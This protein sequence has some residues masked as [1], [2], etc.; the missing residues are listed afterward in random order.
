MKVFID[1]DDVIFNT[2]EFSAGLRKL[3]ESC[4][5]S[6]E[7]FQKNYYD[8]SDNNEIKLFDPEGVFA[9]LEKNEK[10]ETAILREK[11]AQHM[12]DL[13]EFVFADVADFLAETEKKNA[14]LI[15]FGLPVFQNEK[16]VAS[17]IH[18]LVSGCIVTKGSKAEAVRQVMEKMNI[19]FDEKIIFIDD[20]VEQVQDI[21][22]AFPAALTF[23][24]CRKEGR[25]CDQKNE[26]CDYEIHSL[27]EAQEIVSKLK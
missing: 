12:T 16:I 21:K 26:F 1:F 27:R 24:L 11:F 22:K 17:G 3:F 13:S 18:K 8:P 2:K 23:L 9:R 6:Q 20:R 14:Y 25:Y 15:S 7:I 10:M 5:V 19:D 4:G